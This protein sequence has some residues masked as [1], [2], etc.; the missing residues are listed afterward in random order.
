VAIHGVPHQNIDYINGYFEKHRQERNKRNEAMARRIA[1]IF[2][3]FGIG[4]SYKEAAQY[5][6]IEKGG[7]MTERTL[8]YAAALKIID[9]FGKGE[10]IT[11]FLK[12]DLGID[13]G[14]KIATYLADKGNVHYEFDL[15]GAL[16]SGLVS[17]FY[18]DA[19]KECMPAE[20]YITFTK[21]V[22]AISA[23]AYLGD[24]GASVTGDKKAQKFED[25][26]IEELFKYLKDLGFN[27]VTYMP[28][29][30][31]L[32]QLETIR[33]LSAKHSFFEISGEDINS[34]RQSFICPALERP[35]FAHLITSTWA[36]IGHENAAT[37]NIDNGMFTKKTV[38]EMPS[39]SERIAY[40]ANL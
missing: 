33:A 26:Y 10:R 20:E 3:P 19:D 32:T 4:F 5:A 14:E 40:F 1:A 2:A 24:V 17:R 28:S 21:K 22:G 34:S 6:L 27:A 31:T 23:Y 12:E 38:S 36:L 35:E 8:C 39:L 16:K 7:T 18:I 30:N 13:P 25:D 37:A 9:K 11:Q 15:L 29:R